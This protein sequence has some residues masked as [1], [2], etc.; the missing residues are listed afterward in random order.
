MT[1]LVIVESPTKTKTLKKFLGTGYTVEA[2]VGHIL[3]LPKSKM[4]VDIKNGFK[5]EYKIEASKEKTVNTIVSKAKDA[6]TIYLATDPD[7]EGEAISDH[8]HKEIIKRGKIGK[9]KFK[10]IVFHEITK[11]AVEESLKHPRKIDDDLVDAQT[12][13]RVLDRLVGYELSPLLWEK[14]RYG[15][16][17]GRVQSAALRIVMEKEREIRAFI[18]E[19]FFVITAN[20][21]KNGLTFPLVCSVEPRE[22]KEADRIIKEAKAG[23]WKVTGIKTSEVSRKPYA[24]FVTSTMQ[25]T[26]STRLGM[27]PSGA[28]RAAQK[29]YEAGH[30]TY[31]RTDS[32]VLS[33]EAQKKILGM[34]KKDFGEKY[35]QARSFKTKS[36]NAQEAHEAIRPTDVYKRVA[37]NTPAEMKLY[38]LIWERAVASQMADAKLERTKVSANIDGDKIPDFVAR[39]S[40]VLFDGWL[41]VDKRSRKDDVEVPKLTEGDALK[42]KDIERED[43]ETQPPGRYTEAGLIKEL[44]K[45]EIGRPSTYASIIKTLLDREYVEK[46][47]RTLVP[48]DTGDVVSTFLEEHF[49]KYISDNFT[50]DME[51]ELDSIANGKHKYEKVLSDFYKPFHKDVVAKKDIPK[52]N[53][54]GP[55]DKKF[56]CPECGS[57]MVIKLGKN[58][59]FLSCSKYPKCEGALTIDGHKIGEHE[60]IGKHPETGEPI[61]VLTGRYGPYVQLGEKTDDNP[62]PK[63]ASLPKG[64]DLGDVTLDQAVEL[65]I[66]PRTLGKHPE[67][68]EDVISN[69]GR[70]G[71]Y[72]GH[73]RTFRSLKKPLDPYTVTFDEAVKELNKPKALPKGVELVKKLGEHPKT[74]KEIRVLKS[75]TGMFV[76]KGLRRLYFDDAIKEKDVNM[77]M[78]VEL[79]KS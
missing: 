6:D 12:A 40:R 38:S 16:S 1:N 8:I 49:M 61:F 5:P 7:R 70:F 2:T 29:L 74:G 42:L 18:P 44:E 64:I 28:M 17:A 14:L 57:S 48:T 71:P 10:R 78:V 27:S 67:S 68:G 60:P 62:K 65:L 63:R 43:K 45:R 19:E 37:G 34:V 3:N 30:I 66:L 50:A 59:K 73:G 36:K 55:A 9:S 54:L 51:N 53:N 32:P 39:G 47:G 46:D 79:L 26:A 56:K 52:I 21:K 23:S 24:P 76:Q 41:V 72:V 25:R 31:M 58:G 13:R 69:I 22:V 4:H 75:K 33:K 11:S 77:D 35:V 15:L 20:F